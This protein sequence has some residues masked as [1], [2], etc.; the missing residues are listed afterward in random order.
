MV[1]PTRLIRR[2]GA[3]VVAHPG[4]EQL[5]HQAAEIVDRSC[6][7][8]SGFAVESLEDDAGPD[9]RPV[10]PSTDDK[11]AIAGLRGTNFLHSGTILLQRLGR[12]VD[13]SAMASTWSTRH[14]AQQPRSQ[15]STTSAQ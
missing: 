13:A 6:A 4:P 3:S 8:R 5:F 2:F 7:N 12:I 10:S 15:S 11:K 1:T 9:F 14:Y